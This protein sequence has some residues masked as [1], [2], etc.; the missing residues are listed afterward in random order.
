MANIRAKRTWV[1]SSGLA[2]LAAGLAAPASAQTVATAPAATETADAN[3]DAIVV[4]G[5]R[6]Q[7]PGLVSNSPIT[8]V[9]SAEIRLQGA[10]SVENVVNRLPQVTADANENVSNG[11]D[12]TARIN[13]RNLGSNRNL[14]LVNGQRLLPV[15]A[16]D[17]NFIPAALVQRIDVVT[18][19]ASAVYG[20]DA[21]S[22]VVNFILRDD[23]QGVHADA[24]YSFSGHR[25]DNEARRSLIGANGYRNAPRSLIDGEKFDANIA[26]GTNFADDRGNVT[27]YFGYRQVKPIL[28]ANRDVSA[29]A[30]DPAD[31]NTAF[32]CGGS[33][34]N[35]FGL[36][37]PL[38]GPSAGLRFN[39][40][41]DGQK[42]WVPYDNSFRYNY[43][44][45]NY[46]QRSDVRYTAGAFAKYEVDPAAELYGSF[47]FM[48]DHTFSQ[49]APSALF[50]GSTFTINCNNPFLS[51]QQG[52]LLCGSDFGTDVSQNLF[53]GY[54]PVA[55]NA[56]PRRDDLR[57]TDYRF[58]GGV[59]G[60]IAEG[61]RY[62]VNAL[63][64]KVLFQENYQNDIDPA[65]ANRALQVV[66][67]NGVPTCKSAVDGSDTGCVPL[68]V[69]RYNGISDD[70][71][72]Y[73]YAPTFTK[74]VDKETVLS[75]TLTGDLAPYGVKLPWA[76]DGV[77]VVLGVEHRRESLLFRA[78]AL[79]QQKGTRNA[80]GKFDVT[81]Y[82]TEVRI[83]IAQ[84]QP[85]AEDLTITGGYRLSDYS[86]QKKMISTYK[87]EITYAPVSDLRFRAS[88]NRAI[89]APNISELFAAQQIG[90]V[91][92][93]D[94][95]SGPTPVATLQQ[96]QLTGV[97]AAQYGRI[98]ECPSEVCSA[99][100]G[101]NPA[102]KPEEADTY[103]LGAVISPRFIPRLSLSVD[104]FNIKVKGYISSI[105]ASLTISQCF[106]TGDPFFCGLFHR[107]TRSGVLFGEAGYVVSTTQNTGSLKTSG[108]DFGAD[109]SVP[110]PWGRL[111]AS[112]VGTWLNE[113][114][115]EPLP[116]LGS[117]DCKGLF[118]PTCGQPS[119]EW[120]HTARLTFTDDDHFGSFS[121]NWRYLGG[122][123]LTNNTSNPFLAGDPYVI[124][125]K[126]PAY[127]YFDL[128]A[129]VNV[130]KDIVMRVGI[131]NVFD[132]DPPAIA[133]GLLSSFGNGNTYPGI[134]DVAG[135]SFFIGLS[136]DF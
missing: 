38:T 100:G 111:S 46:F 113:L 89:R 117:Y 41:R 42:T 3:A 107:D 45:L 103:T 96:C 90:N 70:A 97:T 36:F 66:N 106:A 120:R 27:A 80:D 130:R 53:I 54:R 21:I 79:A 35:E 101:G 1:V 126:L 112:F 99:Q 47:M 67:V 72:G 18:G 63:H 125:A 13:L 75:G 98:P 87:G 129:T 60:E 51:Q 73:I 122:T 10:T 85:F 84:D 86:T 127:S 74:G 48:D 40:T 39:N 124:N 29:C 9:D 62:D 12:G 16:T 102:V 22:G 19:G 116:G 134:Y 88:Y 59:R 50:Q 132:K 58:S 109:Y 133:Q 92:A 25:N 121:V 94:P 26:M 114:V 135:R 6:L 123:K 78:D 32:T 71:F 8:A 69:F 30:L 2:A 91:A 7:Q 81:E 110:I 118:G 31:D 61:I 108:I 14:I 49:V 82:F 77:G 131:N 52:Q 44:P 65:R 93:Q 4:T 23:L 28:Q 105:P 136:A 76:N 37:Q 57:H 15:Q 56:R 64:S 83:P 11:S 68:D 17:V 95:C 24:Q 34:N 104:Y 5:T 119:P 128:A 43:A 33:S 55:G 115:N 20:S